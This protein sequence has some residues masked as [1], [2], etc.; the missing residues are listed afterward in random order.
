MLF[1]RIAAVV[2]LVA[3]AVLGAS[4]PA[5]GEEV[6]VLARNL[7]ASSKNVVAVYDQFGGLTLCKG[8]RGFAQWTV[9]LKTPYTDKFR[10]YLHV[11]YASGERRPCRLTI[12]GQRQPGEIL[13]E[14]TGGFMPA[15][16]RWKAHGPIDFRKGKNTIR[17]DASGYMPHF[18]GLVVSSKSSP[19]K[20]DVFRDPRAETSA[21]RGKLNLKALRRAIEHLAKRFGKKY[22]NSKVFLERVAA[23]ENEL[24]RA[25]KSDAPKVETLQLLVAKT[26]RLRKEALVRDNPLLHFGKLLFVKRYTYQSS[27]YYTD[28][29]DGCR[30]F[31]GS[32]CLLSL[33]DGRVTELAPKLRGGIFGR[34]DLSW[35]AKRVVFSYK[36]GPGRGFRVYQVGTDGRGLR[37]ITSDPADE[38]KRIDKYWLRGVYKDGLYKHHRHWILAL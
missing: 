23:I 32:L 33:V 11:L 3:V 10:G 9:D 16:L 20:Q 21:L 13:A 12:N 30:H 19:S 35:D 38:Q 8:T 37:Q 14:T 29:I 17:I 24:A 22:P 5:R 2:V 28:F 31:G 4:G 7:S 25:T 1:A 18:K 26:D 15:N 6:A 34:F 27:H 36:R